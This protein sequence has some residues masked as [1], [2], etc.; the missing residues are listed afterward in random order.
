MT[1]ALRP[2]RRAPWRSTALAAAVVGRRARTPSPPRAAFRRAGRVRRSRRSLAG[3]GAPACVGLVLVLRRPRTRVAWILLA[4]APSVGVVL[5]A[6]RGGRASRCTTIPA[7]RSAPG[8]CWSRRSGSCCSPGRSRSPTAFPDGRLPSRAGGPP[9]RS[10]SPRAAGAMLLLLVPGDA[11]GP[12]RPGAQPA[13]RPRRER[14]ADGA[15]LGPAGPACWSR[16]SAARSRCAPAT[17]RA[18]R[19]QRRQV[20]WLAY[21]ALLLPLWLGGSSLCEPGPR[22]RSRRRRPRR[23]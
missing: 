7:P 22:R 23:C 6:V 17:G 18:G 10:R 1:R 14:A 11:R 9:R 16:C 13:R 19:V 20:L 4:G 2:H 5:A 12:V 15:V 8:R 3:V 21:G